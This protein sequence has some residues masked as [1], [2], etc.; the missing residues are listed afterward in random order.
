MVLLY[1]SAFLRNPIDHLS[2]HTIGLPRLRS[3]RSP[4]GPYDPHLDDATPNEIHLV[5]GIPNFL[6][7]FY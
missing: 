4:L 2:A 6:D 3:D 1:D 7:F 5:L